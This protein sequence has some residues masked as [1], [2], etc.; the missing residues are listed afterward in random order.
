MVIYVKWQD[1]GCGVNVELGVCG[2][3]IRGERKAVVRSGGVL[4]ER[5]NNSLCMYTNNQ[6]A[7][8]TCL[9]LHALS[10]KY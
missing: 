4:S 1:V 10:L 2:Q 8:R 6:K 5:R 7:H 9:N 3:V